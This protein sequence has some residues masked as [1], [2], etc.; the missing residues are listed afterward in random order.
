MLIK[1][2]DL[3]KSLTFCNYA[4]GDKLFDNSILIGFSGLDNGLIKRVY[5][6]KFGNKNCSQF[7]L[8]KDLGYINLISI[9]YVNDNEYF[10]KL[11][12]NNKK[13]GGNFFYYIYINILKKKDRFLI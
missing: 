6:C 5:K 4:N 12:F 8:F 13:L 7:S 2:I 9:C 11:V 10:Y 3:Q 1:N